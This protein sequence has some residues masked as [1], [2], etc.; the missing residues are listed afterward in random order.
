MKNNFGWGGVSDGWYLIGMLSNDKNDD[1]LL[2]FENLEQEINYTC[3]FRYL[4]FN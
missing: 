1:S 4:F 3:F 2:D